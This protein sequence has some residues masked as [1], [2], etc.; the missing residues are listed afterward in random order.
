M[1]SN[2]S[3]I[4]GEQELLKAQGLIQSVYDLNFKGRKNHPD[5]IK[6]SS[7]FANITYF[8]NG[9]D[10]EIFGHVYQIK[11]EIWYANDEKLINFS[12]PLSKYPKSFM[13]NLIEIT[14]NYL[15]GTE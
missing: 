12:I 3:V 15:A 8:P 1:E 13:H 9:I 11:W 7:S 5:W 2:Q 4:A 10:F 14:R 6:H